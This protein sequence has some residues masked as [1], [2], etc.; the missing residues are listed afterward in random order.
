MLLIKHHDSP[1]LNGARATNAVHQCR[2]MWLHDTSLNIMTVHQDHQDTLQYW[3]VLDT[4]WL[5]W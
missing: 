2:Q 1:G 5:Q 3:P 4:R